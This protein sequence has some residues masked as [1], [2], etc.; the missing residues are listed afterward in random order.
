MRA[1]ARAAAAT[2]AGILEAAHRLLNQR[3]RSDPHAAG[4][5]VGCRCEPGHDLQERGLEGPPAGG[6]LRGPGAVDRIRSSAGSHGGGEPGPCSGHHDPRELPGL[7]G[8]AGRHTQDAGAGCARRGDRSTGAELRTPPP[9]Q[10]GGTGTT[11]VWGRYE[12]NATPSAR[13]CGG[14]GAP[15]EFHNLRPTSTRAR[16]QAIHRSPRPDGESVAREIWPAIEPARSCGFRPYR[17]LGR[18]ASRS[19]G[20]RLQAEDA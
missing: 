19:C 3:D 20:F 17:P 4:S 15:H 8:D 12:G 11:S 16:R 5:R 7:V 9:R 10:I 14:A 18:V 6:R 13:S 1:R 2:R